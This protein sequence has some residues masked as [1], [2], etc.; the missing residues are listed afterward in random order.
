MN[1]KARGGVYVDVDEYEY[2]F[3]FDLFLGVSDGLINILIHV[4]EGG[5]SA[6][7][8]KNLSRGPTL[9]F[10]MASSRWG[11]GLGVKVPTGIF[12][13]LPPT[14]PMLQIFFKREISPQESQSIGDWVGGPWWSLTK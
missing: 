10:I 11:V 5:N 3:R 8:F 6:D 7:W 9:D 1:K 14:S 13:P 2:P 12:S 4:T